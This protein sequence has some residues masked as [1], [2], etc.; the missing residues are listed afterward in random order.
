MAEHYG[1]LS[2][3]FT[4]CTR[5]VRGEAGYADGEGFE[6]ALIKTA[7]PEGFSGECQGVREGYT[8]VVKAGVTL[9]YGEAF[10]R[11]SD[12]LI[13]RVTSN[14]RDGAAPAASSVGV[15]KCSAERWEAP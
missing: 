1:L 4:R 13:F 10:R 7:S 15:A 3:L 12:G 11:E 8:V 14:T 6:A 5:L 2:T 9:Q